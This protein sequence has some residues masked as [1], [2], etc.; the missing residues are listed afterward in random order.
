MIGEDCEQRSGCRILTQLYKV[1]QLPA[2]KLK[3]IIPYSVS[4]KPLFKAPVGRSVDDFIAESKIHGWPSF[5]DEEVVWS[6]VRVLRSS[7]ETVSLVSSKLKYMQPLVLVTFVY[8]L[9]CLRNLT[10]LI[11]Q[12]GTHLGH[13]LPDQNGNRYCINLVSIAGNPVPS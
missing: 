1:T 11:I 10:F 13:N 2:T 5:R 4:G 9:S 3:Y 8:S 12:D 7:G 6:N